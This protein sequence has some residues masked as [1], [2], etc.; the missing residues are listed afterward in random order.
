MEQ[1]K[2]KKEKMKNYKVDKQITF[3]KA[4][5]SFGSMEHSAE[6]IT[7]ILLFALNEC[8]KHGVDNDRAIGLAIAASL[9]LFVDQNGPEATLG[10]IG[11]TKQYLDQ[12]AA[13][14]VNQVL[15]DAEDGPG[16]IARLGY[17]PI[18]TSSGP[19]N[20]GMQCIVRAQSGALFLLDVFHSNAKMHLI[21][22]E[23]ATEWVM[24]YGHPSDT[25]AIIERLRNVST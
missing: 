1:D 20:L 18:M 10:F 19:V 14:L 9:S 2:Q 5:L 6:I 13:N 8:Q 12:A 11:E 15:Y 4:C 23:E 16:I 22:L 7:N 21:T 25:N 3:E 24:K 17:D